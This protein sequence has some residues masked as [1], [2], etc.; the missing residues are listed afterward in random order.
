MELSPILALLRDGK[1]TQ[2][3]AARLMDIPLAQLLKVASSTGIPVIA[4][5]EEGF[6]RELSEIRKEPKA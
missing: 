2:Q 1:L 6:E 3:Q 4:Y 5:D